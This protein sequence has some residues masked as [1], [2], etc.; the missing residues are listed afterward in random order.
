MGFKKTRF[1]LTQHFQLDKICNQKANRCQRLVKV[2]VVEVTRQPQLTSHV[3]SDLLQHFR[4]NFKSFD[5]LQIKTYNI[6]VEK[7]LTT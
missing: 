5:F 4:W 2:S 1:S 6:S 3:V 7:K